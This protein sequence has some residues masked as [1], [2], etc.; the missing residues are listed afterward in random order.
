MVSVAILRA[1]ERSLT[2]FL[3]FWI[4]R[5]KPKENLVLILTIL[6]LW[7]RKANW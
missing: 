3:T 5:V 1:F 2:V 4:S 6:R 7:F